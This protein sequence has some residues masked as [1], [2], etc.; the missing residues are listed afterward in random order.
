[1]RAA[2]L[3]VKETN[4]V[5]LLLSLRRDCGHTFAAAC[6][7]YCLLY[8][9]C[10]TDITY[11]SM[12]CGSSSPSAAIAVTQLCI[13]EITEITEITAVVFRMS[14]DMCRMMRAS[15]YAHVLASC[16]FKH[17]ALHYGDY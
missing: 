7:D 4:V 5:W 2:C 6:S 8:F 9:S 15:R 17:T 11:G 1:M 3:F 14:A 10:I 13:T 16:L 12:L